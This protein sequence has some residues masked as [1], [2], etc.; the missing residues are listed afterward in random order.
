MSNNSIARLLDKA[1]KEYAL[2]L[3]DAELLLAFVTKLSR[4]KIKISLDQILDHGTTVK[5]LDLVKQR[6]QGMP[7]AYLVGY[8]DFWTFTLTVNEHVLIPRIDTEVLVETALN[9]LPESLPL[10]VLDLGTGSGA[11][12]LALASERPLLQ[13]VGVDISVDAINL[14]KFNAKQLKINNI[15]FI[16]SDWLVNVT[17]KFDM[18]V[19]NPP[20]IAEN[21]PMLAADVAKYEPAIALYAGMHGLSA[22]ESILKNINAHLHV[23]GYFIVEHG[24]DQGESVRALLQNAGFIN[25]TT[26]NDLAG[27]SRV[28]LGI[29]DNC[30]AAHIVSL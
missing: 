23:G 17:G 13:V 3:L 11:I 8:K 26:V 10:K 19:A 28:S 29:K 24:C 22:M 27:H 5:F 18:I 16:E 6:A 12:A 25:V 21:S 14:A 2:T 4:V 9:Y 15:T 7:I 30:K 1:T 20:Y